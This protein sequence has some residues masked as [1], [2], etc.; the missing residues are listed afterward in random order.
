VATGAGRGGEK[1]AP[2]SGAVLSVSRG[3]GVH[4]GGVSMLGKLSAHGCAAIAAVCLYL[5]YERSM[6]DCGR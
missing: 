3:N 1:H 2:W 5:C 6:T 4:E